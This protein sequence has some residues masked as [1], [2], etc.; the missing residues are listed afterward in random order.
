LTGGDKIAAR[1]SE[2]NG[3]EP[4]NSLA[5]AVLILKPEMHPQSIQ[6]RPN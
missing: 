5:R 1:A 4:V 2:Q 3:Q 6:L